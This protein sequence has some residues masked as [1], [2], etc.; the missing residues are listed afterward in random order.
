MTTIEVVWRLL[1]VALLVA[2]NGFFVAAE[3]A[4]VGAKDSRLA[5]L[6]AGGDRLARVA[7]KAKVELNLY[8]SS[9]QVGI[10]LASLGLG[11]IGE[12]AI[13]QTLIA[14]FSGLPAPFDF[15]ARHAVAVIIA[16][17]MITYLHV[18]FGEVAPK[19]LAIFHPEQVARWLVEP[20]VWFT[21][22]GHPLIW[23]INEAANTLLKV[24]GVRLPTEAEMAHSPEEIIMLVRASREHGVV[25]SEEQEMISGV[26]ELT[27]TVAR[28]VMTPRPDIVAV[29]TDAGF[30][31]VVAATSRS[32]FSRLP[33]YRESLDNVVGVLLVKDLLPLAASG[34]V[35]GFDVS[36]IMR[37]PYFVPDTKS[38][39][40]LLTE[41]LH[42]KIHMAIVVDEFGGTD[43][44]VTLEDLIEE[45]V[46]EIYDEHDVARPIFSTTPR[47]EPLIDGSAPIDEV[48]EEYDLTLPV[49]DYDT[50][51][52]FIL[53]EL[54]QVPRHGDFVEVAGARL[55]VEQVDERRVRSVRLLRTDGPDT[56]SLQK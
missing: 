35:S 13:A 7:R 14:L 5:N 24:I 10:T 39:D 50:L 52:G 56:G 20:L 38:V 53:G 29:P 18:V 33:V 2:A 48:N 43:G 17:T 30:D 49:E 47:G 4:L 34:D 55:V 46:G 25:D 26:F 6:E 45:I 37:E 8:L 27:R 12:P 41:F 42:L 1:A 21:R 15:L 3:F 36:R 40:D 23:S 54:G 16:F 51:G 22:L 28:E 19:A 9:C 44:L 32:G 31:D 11:W